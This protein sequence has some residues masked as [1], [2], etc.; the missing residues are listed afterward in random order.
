MASYFPCRAY[1]VIGGMPF[2]S[3]LVIAFSVGLLGLSRDLCARIS[4]EEAWWTLVEE[5]V[6]V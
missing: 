3:E 5:S 6:V 2:F 4:M 1:T